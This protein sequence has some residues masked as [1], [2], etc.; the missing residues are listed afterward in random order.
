ML[1][2]CPSRPPPAPWGWRTNVPQTW[3]P[4]AGFPHVTCS[5]K[6]LSSAPRVSRIDPSFLSQSKG[7]GQGVLGSAVR[8]GSEHPA[9]CR[10]SRSRRCGEP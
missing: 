1:P 5:P 9:P 8:W 7:R 4:L 2:G 6:H 10:P 3:G